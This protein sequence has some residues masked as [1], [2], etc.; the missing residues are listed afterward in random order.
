METKYVVINLKCSESENICG[1]YDTKEEA[2]DIEYLCNT[3]CNTSSYVAIPYE[4]LH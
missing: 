3:L 1:I 4:I 2:D